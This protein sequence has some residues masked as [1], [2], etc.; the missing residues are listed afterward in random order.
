MDLKKS[1]HAVAK[2]ALS[3]DVDVQHPA[4]PAVGGRTSPVLTDRILLQGLEVA[5]QPINML[6]VHH[7]PT[8]QTFG[9]MLSQFVSL[10]SQPSLSGKNMQKR[11]NVIHSNFFVAHLLVDLE[12]LKTGLPLSKSSGSVEFVPK[13]SSSKARSCLRNPAL[14]RAIGRLDLT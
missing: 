7:V 9:N 4:C 11:R 5:I 2:G 8:L 3:V 6:S 1:C 13:V 12:E 14:G 10:Y